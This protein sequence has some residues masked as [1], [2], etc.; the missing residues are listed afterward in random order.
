MMEKIS[1]VI[2]DDEFPA[3][4]LLQTYIEKLPRLDLKG[5]FANPLEGIEVVQ[6]E[7]VEL[8]FL[9]IQMPEISGIELMRS[10]GTNQ[11]MVV[12]TTAYPDYA[13]EGFELDVLD[14]LVKPIAFE[15]FMQ[16]VGRASERIR[17]KNSAADII[18]PMPGADYIVVKADYKVYRIKYEDILYIEGLGEYVSFYTTSGRIITLESL[19]KLEERL[20]VQHFLRVHKSYI[21]NKN[22]INYLHGNELDLNGK[23]IPVGKMY[24]DLTLKN[25][26]SQH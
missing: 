22:R 9:D 26:F 18:T 14:Y 17:L 4:L 13:L 2:I 23:M 24:K 25:I 19:K 16:T 6:N 11:P 15:R 21:V 1:C 10:M 8:I 12:F 3:R 7:D 20:P 5:A